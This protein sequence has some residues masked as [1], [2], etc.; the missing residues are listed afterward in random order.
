[1]IPT[2]GTVLKLRHATVSF[3]V[4][5]SPETKAKWEIDATPE[6]AFKTKEEYLEFVKSWKAEYK[7]VSKAILMLKRPVGFVCSQNFPS[8]YLF[9]RYYWPTSLAH[10]ALFFIRMM[11]KALLM[12]RSQARTVAVLQHAQNC[13]K[14]NNMSRTVPSATNTHS[15]ETKTPEAL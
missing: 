2:Q 8:G 1:M 7:K 4:K 14:C 12:L 15:N 6:F 10:T 9:G 3:K 5:C 11:A 13:P